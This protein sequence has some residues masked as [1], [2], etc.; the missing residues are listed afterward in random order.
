MIFTQADR[1]RGESLEGLR[2]GD[3]L[4]RDGHDPAQP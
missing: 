4:R 3:L 2:R 1:G